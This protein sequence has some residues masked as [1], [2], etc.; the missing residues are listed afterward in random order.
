MG[1]EVYVSVNANFL[2]VS[3]LTLIL[4]YHCRLLPSTSPSLT[5]PQSSE[6]VHGR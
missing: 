2:T 4:H 5:H 1:M 6:E 3:P